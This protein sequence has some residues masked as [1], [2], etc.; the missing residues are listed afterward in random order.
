MGK[1]Y[2][3]VL[4]VK[5]NAT[6]EE[7]K[8]AYKKLALK[9]HP[10]K[11]HSLE[12]GTK[13]KEIVKAYEILTDKKKKEIYDLHRKK[14]RDS[15]DQEV[16]K[17]YSYMFQDGI[18]NNFGNFFRF[19]T[20]F[21]NV[22][23][24]SC[25]NGSKIFTLRHDPMR[26]SNPFKSFGQYE[27]K[28]CNFRTPRFKIHKSLS[29]EKEN[30]KNKVT[31]REVFV[32]LEEILHGCTKKVRVTKTIFLMNGTSK[33][34]IQI[35]TVQIRPGW[36]AGTKIIFRSEESQTKTSIGDVAFIIRDKPHPIFKRDGC[37][38]KYMAQISLKEALCGCEIEIP[39][40]KGGKV[41]LKLPEGILRPQTQKTLTGLGLPLP[42]DIHKRGDLIVTFNIIF[43]E[44][45]PKHAKNIL[46]EALS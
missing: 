7:I 31:E 28:K 38:L 34:E 1:S 15:I 35:F 40:L 11:N 5:D 17:K 32:T 39:T 18:K 37:N 27:I 42:K 36:K 2:Y 45:L 23:D 19:S 29:L 44:T 9:F 41:M 10:D 4:Q 20:T 25:V 14:V 30:V 12:A 22:F 33:K 8:K 24:Y 13:F 21:H 16:T 6:N 46:R 3:E 43:P 26:I